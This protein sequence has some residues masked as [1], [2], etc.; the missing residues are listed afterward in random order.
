MRSSPKE[1][2]ELK[3]S[4]SAG[5][6]ETVLT[7]FVKT[8]FPLIPIV[9]L[10]WAVTMI[11]N[12][13]VAGVYRGV[14][15]G[16]GAI[17]LDLNEEDEQLSGRI[18]L[19]QHE[20]YSIVDGKMIADTK[21]QMHLQREQ[22]GAISSVSSTAPVSKYQSLPSESAVPDDL[23]N[24]SLAVPQSKGPVL[25]I[26]ATK[27]QNNLDGTLSMDGK[28]IHFHAYR[29]SLSSF[30]GKRWFNRTLSY[31]GLKQKK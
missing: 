13:E 12:M 22:P 16:I 24:L 25:S 27:E 6:W 29:N 19:R 14:I 30:F 3:K 15:P 2:N 21:M 31:F 28:E 1:K 4:F 23:S 18:T 5:L 20:H 9:I 8:V 7:F 11:L 17:M 26:E 10:V